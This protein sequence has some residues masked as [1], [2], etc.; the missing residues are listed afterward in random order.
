MT[1]KW[2]MG[3]LNVNCEWTE[4]KLQMNYGWIKCELWVN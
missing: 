1:Y 4:N 3:E 2:I